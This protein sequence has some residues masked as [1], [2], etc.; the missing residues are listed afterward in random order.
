MEETDSREG[1]QFIQ[2][3][4]AD[5][6]RAE[7]D[8][9]HHASDTVLFHEETCTSEPSIGGPEI[10]ARCLPEM[11]PWRAQQGNDGKM[12]CGCHQPAPWNSTS[13]RAEFKIINS[14]RNLSMR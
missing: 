4:T 13:S 7:V 6:G 3:H 5:R 10:M 9:R 12:T 11:Y 8:R 2:G 14:Q 1:K